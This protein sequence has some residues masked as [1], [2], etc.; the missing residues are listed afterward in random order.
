VS[1]YFRLTRASICNSEEDMTTNLHMTALCSDA[2][3]P[4]L[5]AAEASVCSRSTTLHNL[6][7]FGSLCTVK[8]YL[9]PGRMRRLLSSVV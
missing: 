6:S 7:T 8:L 2:S 9:Q 1:S 3:P 5:E 4:F